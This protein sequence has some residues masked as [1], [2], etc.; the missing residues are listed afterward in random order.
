MLVAPGAATHAAGLVVAPAAT[1]QTAAVRLLRALRFLRL[2]QRI[3]ADHP[4]HRR[5]GSQHDREGDAS[6][7][8]AEKFHFRTPFI[9]LLTIRVDRRSWGLSIGWFQV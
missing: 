4:N 6:N 3:A 2:S 7:E 5:T 1:G 8:L 9:T